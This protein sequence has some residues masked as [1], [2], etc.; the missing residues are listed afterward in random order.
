MTTKAVLPFEMNDKS[1]RPKIADKAQNINEYKII[2]LGFPIWWYEA[3]RIIHSFLDGYDFANKSIIPF[4]TSGS[5]GLG[6]TE[7]ILKKSCPATNWLPGKR[8]PGNASKEDVA[9][10]AKEFVDWKA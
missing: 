8:F 3:P 9:A 7:D 1:S 5:S 2:F 4:A 6:S 10:W